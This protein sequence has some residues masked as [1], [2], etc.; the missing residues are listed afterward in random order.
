MLIL[1][2]TNVSF[3]HSC[4]FSLTFHVVVLCCYIS[5]HLIT[6]QA[7]ISWDNLASSPL[8]PTPT[9]TPVKAGRGGST[10]RCPRAPTPS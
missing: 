2:Y 1:I 7:A 4:L 3:L 8:S 5:L 10:S 9:P 6:L